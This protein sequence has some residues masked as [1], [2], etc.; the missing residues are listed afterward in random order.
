MGTFI[1]LTSYKNPLLKEQQFFNRENYYVSNE[2]EFKNIPNSIYAYEVSERTAECFE[3]DP[4]GK[5]FVTR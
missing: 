2:N 1:S 3:F 4:L 5:H